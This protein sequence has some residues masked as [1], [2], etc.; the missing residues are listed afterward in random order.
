[1]KYLQKQNYKTKT[2]YKDNKQKN[3]YEIYDKRIKRQ[4]TKRLIICKTFLLQ[5]ICI[6]N[7]YRNLRLHDK[8]RG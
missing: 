5:I 8:G 6:Q 2:T 3:L 4:T 7:I 1:M